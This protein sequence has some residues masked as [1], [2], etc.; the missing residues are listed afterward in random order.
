MF[1]KYFLSQINLDLNV[2]ENLSDYYEIHIIWDI[3]CLVGGFEKV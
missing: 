1:Q 2:P 3:E